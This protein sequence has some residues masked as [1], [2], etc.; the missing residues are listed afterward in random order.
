MPSRSRAKSRASPVTVQKSAWRPCV[1]RSQVY[2]S[3]LS[4]QS[5]VSASTL[6]PSTSWQAASRHSIF[7]RKSSSLARSLGEPLRGLRRWPPDAFRQKRFIM[8]RGQLH[9]PELNPTESRQGFLDR[10]VLVV[11]AASLV[12]VIVAFLVLPTL[13]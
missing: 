11:L 7:P 3:C 8:R 12:L 5:A 4:R 9:N 6:G 2:C 1:A 13:V 10:P